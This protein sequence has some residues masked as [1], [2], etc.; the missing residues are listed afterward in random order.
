MP[1]LCLNNMQYYPGPLIPILSW[2]RLQHLEVDLLFGS[3]QGSGMWPWTWKLKEKQQKSMDAVWD[4]KPAASL[5]QIA[6]SRSYI[7]IPYALK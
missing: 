3:A 4:Y 5:L 2:R 7:Y 6:R 1:K